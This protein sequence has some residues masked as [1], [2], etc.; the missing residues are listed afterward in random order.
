M[1]ANEARPTSICLPTCPTTY[2]RIWRYRAAWSSSCFPF[3]EVRPVIRH[4]ATSC[5]VG[6]PYSIAPCC[7]PFS[8]LSSSSAFLGRLLK[9]SSHL[10]W[11]LPRPLQHPSLFISALF[12]NHS[13]FILT[14]CQVDFNWLLI[15]YFANY[16]SQLLMLDISFSFCTLS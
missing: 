9:R 1:V 4:S 8:A 12:G 5:T 2:S 13:S 10:S 14:T 3:V 6:P 11:G 15:N 16:T 7:W